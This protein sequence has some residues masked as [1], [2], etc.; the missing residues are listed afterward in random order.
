MSSLT[1]SEYDVLIFDCYGTLVDWQ[2]AITSYWQSVLKRHDAHVTD[3]FLLEFH[4]KWEPIEQSSGGLYRDVLQRVMKRLGD[5]LAFTPSEDELCGFIASLA[6]SAPFEDAVQSLQLLGQRFELAVIS[7]TDLNIIAKT[8]EVFDRQF[9]YLITAEETGKYKPVPIM[10]SN[11]MKTIG[12][13]KR[14]LY[15]AQSLYHDIQPANVLGIDSVWIDRQKEG[16]S[17]LWHTQAKP[18]WV[19]QDLATFT[20]TVLKLSAS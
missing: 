7:N 18:T 16:D 1:A 2:T 12:D 9:D 6:Q 20:A 13:K 3:E 15:V 4:A 10:M 11:A 8:L 19:F 14:K 17:G 5:R